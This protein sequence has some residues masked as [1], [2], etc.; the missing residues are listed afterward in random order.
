MPSLDQCR[1]IAQAIDSVLAQPEVD[2][3]IVAD[4]G[5]TDG[6]LPL[7]EELGRRRARRLRWSSAPDSGPADA[8]NRAVRQARGDI[9]GWLNSDDL[10]MPGAAAR[11][12]AAFAA[13]PELSMVYGEGRHVDEAGASIDR[14]PTLPPSTPIDA[15]ANG[16]FICQPTA[17][18]RRE[19][20]V[21]LGGLD[22]ALKTAFDFDLWLRMFRA[23]A[24]RIGFV[25]GEQA[26]S[27]L[28]ASGIT[29]REREAVALEGMRVLHR[30]LGSAPPEWLL[31]AFAEQAAR[32]PF[33]DRPLPLRV[34]FARLIDTAASWTDEDGQA[35]L[36]QRLQTDVAWKLATPHLFLEVHPDGWAS[37][38]LEI[39]VRQTA[40]PAVALRLR[41]RHARP[42]GGRLCV[43]AEVPGLAP[44][45]FE[46]ADN[47]SFTWIVRLP[48]AGSGSRVT[49]Q[50]RTG[51]FFVPSTA[52]A[53]SADARELAYLVDSAE[54]VSG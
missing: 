34:H 9:I 46:L 53:A 29:L 2:E 3:L 1:F 52:D 49:L 44:Q 14:Y 18:F 32:H 8:I 6:T 38:L 30:H 40:P 39:R 26:V 45:R 11:A 17:F 10:Y 7:L 21:D 41:G 37:P 50:L 25:D 23:F 33:A 4:G 31:T 28:H 5:S 43:M 24:P 27:R 12:L 48:K 20:F 16:C 47:G 51:D 13:K 22:E 19:A 35:R 36:R 15:F 42:G 54:L